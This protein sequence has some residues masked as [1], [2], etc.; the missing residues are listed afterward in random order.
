MNSIEFTHV[1]EV[2]DGLLAAECGIGALVVE[3]QEDIE[4]RLDADG[5]GA[6]SVASAGSIGEEQ[7]LQLPQPP[8]HRRQSISGGGGG[9]GGGGSGSGRGGGSAGS[10]GGGRCNG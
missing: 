6:V 1:E 7:P 9:S 3:D 8:I 2:G 10:G 5:V 4:E